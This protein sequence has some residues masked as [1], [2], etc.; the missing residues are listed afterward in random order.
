MSASLVSRRNLRVLNEADPVQLPIALVADFTPVLR[1]RLGPDADVDTALRT[2]VHEVSACTV[3]A[4]GGAP[5]EVLEDAFGW[6]R[7][8]LAEDWGVNGGPAARRLTAP[9][10]RSR[11]G[12]SDHDGSRWELLCDALE[13]SG[14]LNRHNRLR[15]LRPCVQVRDTP[16][17]LVVQVDDAAR[18]WIDKHYLAGLEASLTAIAP[19][20]RLV[21]V[22]DAHVAPEGRRGLTT[23][24]TRA[25]DD[26]VSRRAAKA[27]SA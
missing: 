25:V 14:T 8:R 13:G 22:A 24:D 3:A 20:C 21:L 16:E 11:A 5:R 1:A 4:H 23:P 15:W 19:G 2:W 6:W 27:V 10:S 9:A 12:Q 18:P 7:Q 26:D 17:E